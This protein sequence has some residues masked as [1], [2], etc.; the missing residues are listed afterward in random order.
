M[1]LQQEFPSGSRLDAPYQLFNP[2]SAKVIV[3]IATS[4]GTVEYNE[5]SLVMH[6]SNVGLGSTVAFEQYGQVNNS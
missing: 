1:H 6:Q 3:S 5:L 4:E 2:R